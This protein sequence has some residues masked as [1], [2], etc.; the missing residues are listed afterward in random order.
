[1]CGLVSVGASSWLMAGT[2]SIYPAKTPPP[3]LA[4]MSGQYIHTPFIMTGRIIATCVDAWSKSTRAW[5]PSEILRGLDFCA[6]QGLRA[7][8]T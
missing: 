2:S 1:M 3:T 6:D 5:G 4:F 8:H 7:Q